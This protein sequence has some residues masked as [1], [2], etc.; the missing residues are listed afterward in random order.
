MNNV[1]LLKCFYLFV[2]LCLN[3]VFNFFL[4]KLPY[5]IIYTYYNKII[6]KNKE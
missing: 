4:K 3:Y 6:L 5:C 2:L 1:I